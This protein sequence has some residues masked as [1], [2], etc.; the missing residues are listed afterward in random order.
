[1]FKFEKKRFKIC[2][3]NVKK[4]RK[5]RKY[6]KARK[7]NFPKKREL[8]KKPEKETVTKELK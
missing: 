2:K 8:G 7:L 3:E 1:M 4:K 5:T 6:L